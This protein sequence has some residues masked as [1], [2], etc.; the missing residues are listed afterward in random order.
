MVVV[1]RDTIA[2]AHGRWYEILT[3]VGIDAKFL[4][5]KQ[6]PCPLCS[7]TDRWTYSNRS[8]EGDYVCR[9]C[10]AGKGL[11]LVIRFTGWDFKRAAD[12]VDRIVGNLPAKAPEFY[13]TKSANPAS[14]RWMWRESVRISDDDPVHRYLKSRGLS[15]AGVL[16]ALHYAPELRYYRDNTMHPAMIA[17]FSDA[18][19]KPA[20]IHRTFLTPDGAKADLDPC[21][22]FMPGKVPDGG[23]VR[24]FEAAEDM[25]IA[26]GI[27]TALSARQMFGMPVW[28]TTTEGLLQKWQPPAIAKRICIFG[29]NDLN[30]VGQAAAYVLAK[31]LMLEAQRDNVERDVMVMIPDIAGFDWND[32][33]EKQVTMT[34]CETG[35]FSCAS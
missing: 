17:V 25:G 35:D 24:L 6:G 30:Y 11:Q 22:M 34:I 2:A 10:G 9:R 23:A 29:D 28:A 13:A 8:N 14:L 3:A 26:E 4:T 32:A 18:S 12:E 33:I 20:T 31:R 7:G 5:G 27:E 21:R 19:G 15:M 1:M 16:H